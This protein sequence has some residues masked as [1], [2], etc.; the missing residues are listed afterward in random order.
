VALALGEIDPAAFSNAFERCFA[1]VHAYVARRTDNRES[2]ERI[3]SAVLVENWELLIGRSDE[4]QEICRLRRSADRLIGGEVRP[5]IR[6][7]A[8]RK[9]SAV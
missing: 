5:T 4:A 1:R 7:A 2:L 3:V 6:S 9:V 8:P